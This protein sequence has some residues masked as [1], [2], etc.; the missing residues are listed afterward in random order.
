MSFCS[1]C[2]CLFFVFLL[3]PFTFFEQ[4]FCQI[5]LKNL[6]MD[7]AKKCKTESDIIHLCIYSHMTLCLG[8]SY[9]EKWKDV[10]KEIWEEL[11]LPLEQLCDNPDDSPTASPS[12]SHLHSLPVSPRSVRS[13][14]SLL[15]ALPQPR[16]AENSTM[17]D[18][19]VKIFQFLKK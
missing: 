18:K 5:F 19:Y 16:S 13:N 6:L 3:C 1:L 17:P 8:C 9:C 14:P 11:N 4:L 15:S 2:I 10:L 7:C 12:A